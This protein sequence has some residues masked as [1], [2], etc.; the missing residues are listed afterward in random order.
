MRLH[1]LAAAANLRRLLMLGL[2]VATASGCWPDRLSVD[3]LITWPSD[4][5]HRRPRRSAI[6][7]ADTEISAPGLTL[8]RYVRFAGEPSS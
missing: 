6:S 8:R 7:R 3:L 1:A 4:H 5:G 2:A